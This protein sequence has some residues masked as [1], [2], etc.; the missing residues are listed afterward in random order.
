[1]KKVALIIPSLNPDQKLIEYVKEAI[2]MGFK[3]IIIVNDGSS[4]EYDKFFNELSKYNECIVLKHATNL[5][6]GR[7]LKTAFQYYLNK[8][9]DFTGVV[10]ADS[11]GQ[12]SLKDTLKIANEIT[13]NSLVL[14][15]R[16]FN[17]K[18]VPFKSRYGN[19]ITT[20][21]FKTLYGKKIN[22][23]Q[24]GLR[25]LSN[26][27]IKHSLNLNGEGFEYEINML[28]E[29]IRNKTEIKEVFIRTI[30][31]EDNKSSHFNPIKDSIKIYKVMFSEFFKLHFSKKI[32]NEKARLTD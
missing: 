9:N 6:K 16:N 4:K 21:I 10:T 2:K 11:D 31:I 29:A 7:A 20:F 19:K 22:D 27:F 18:Q 30:Y 15:M 17:E 28:I 12:H 26:D 24:T 25:G 32:S 5:G 13:D 23:T 1:M 14:G 8:F 3:N